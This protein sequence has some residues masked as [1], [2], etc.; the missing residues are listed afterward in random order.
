MAQSGLQVRDMVFQRLFG[1]SDSRVMELLHPM[2]NDLPARW[3]IFGW[4]A[5]CGRNCAN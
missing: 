2:R 3:H 5:E 4:K 1:Y